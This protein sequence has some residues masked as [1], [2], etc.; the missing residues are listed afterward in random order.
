MAE[1]IS[2][3]NP[4][5]LRRNYLSG[6]DLIFQSVGTV[7]PSACMGLLLP[8]IFAKSG[9]ESW[10]CML[11]AGCGILLLAT[12]M[13][14]FGR[15]MAS[16]GA[17]YAYVHAGLGPVAGVITG[18]SVL[19]AYVLFIATIPPQISN[20]IGGLLH[21]S[22]GL[23]LQIGIMIA[24]VL[25]PWWLAQQDVRLSARVTSVIEMATMLLVLFLVG[26][27]FW[28]SG[29]IVDHQQLDIS[30]F[31][32]HPF[33]LGLVLAFLCFGGFESA[34]ELGAEAKHPF[35]MIPRILLIVVGLLTLFFVIATYGI[36]A[37][38]HGIT[39]DLGQQDSPLITLSRAL[40]IGHVGVIVTGGFLCSLL[41]SSLGCINAAARVLYAFAHRGLFFP[42]IGKTH[43]RHGTPHYAIAAVTTIGVGISLTLTACGLGTLDQ[44][45]YIGTISS[46]S[47]LASYL[48]VAIAAPFYARQLGELTAWRVI[49]AIVTVA[50]LCVP[51]SGCLYP[52]PDYPHNLL[53]YI[54]LALI[55][56]GT[57]YF[58][59]IR[60]TDPARLGGLESELLNVQAA[61]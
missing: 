7:A 61:G 31:A 24:S 16:P 42:A 57:G 19:L 39:P 11:F 55:A 35:V 30:Q 37:A 47:I 26:T 43:K 60:R 6:F 21:I 46:F 34:M 8:V 48:M 13:N 4:A 44:L 3:P 17:L 52:V 59:F 20:L 12:Q 25:L 10:L 5:G 29:S 54:F 23:P 45:D 27:Y 58:L 38:F 9:M 36:V 50:L 2:Q 32:F 1:Q 15:R 22:F 33:H 18:W 51:L 53:P 41:A 49:G 40:G 14:V 56:L 28:K